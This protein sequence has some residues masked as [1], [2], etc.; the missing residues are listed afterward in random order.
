TAALWYM[1]QS[2]E[3]E[4][5]AKQC[6]E[7]CRAI[8]WHR[9]MAYPMRDLAEI[10]IHRRSFD[11]A[12]EFLDQARTLAL[13]YEDKRQ[14]ARVQLTEARLPL[15]RR[16][17]AAARLK[18]AVAEAEATKLGLPA[19]AEEAGALRVAAGRA[20][21]FFPLGLYYTWRRPTRLTDAPVGGD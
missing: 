15:L 17:F 13:N 7:T 10:A 18:A 20:R 6:L 3:A 16:Q 8:P 14:L 5:A 12:T 19:E 21:V 2:E 4:A 11:E 9:A 1:G